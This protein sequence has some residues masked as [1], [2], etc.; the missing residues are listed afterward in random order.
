MDDDL[1]TSPRDSWCAWATWVLATNA[2]IL[3][4]AVACFTLGVVVATLFHRWGH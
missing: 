4:F 3:A 1:N 2:V